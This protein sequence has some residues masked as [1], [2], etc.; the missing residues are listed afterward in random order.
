MSKVLVAVL[1]FGLCGITLAGDMK[2]SEP[3]DSIRAEL[4]L[5]NNIL[6]NGTN[7]DGGRLTRDYVTYLLDLPRSATVDLKG[8]LVDQKKEW[9]FIS[10]DKTVIALFTGCDRTFVVYDLRGK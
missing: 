1:L 4:T 2:R 7:T 10:P 6:L 5:R 9:L 8:I 3:N